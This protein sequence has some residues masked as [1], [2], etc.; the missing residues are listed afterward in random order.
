MKGRRRR[1]AVREKDNR[2]GRGEKEETTQKK[3]RRQKTRR[4]RKKKAN[5]YHDVDGNK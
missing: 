4:R 2:E 1:V 3:Y 5:N